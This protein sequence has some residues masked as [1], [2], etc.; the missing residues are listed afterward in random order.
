M[1]KGNYV[2]T[3][4]GKIGVIKTPSFIEI[5]F[6]KENEWKCLEV[7][8]GFDDA[9]AKDS[10]AY[11]Q[12]TYPLSDVSIIKTPNEVKL[13]NNI[14]NISS[15]NLKVIDKVTIALNEDVINFLKTKNLSYEFQ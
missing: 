11:W 5:G 14:Y 4:K 3:S 9:L 10:L 8:M 13:G 1:N 12:K 6:H 7:L 15:E 2:L